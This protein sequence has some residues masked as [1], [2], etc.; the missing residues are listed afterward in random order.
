MCSLSSGAETLRFAVVAGNNAGSATMAPLRYAETDAGKFARVLVEL[1]EVAPQ[2]MQLLQGRPVRD[3]EQALAQVRQQVEQTKR[4]PETRTVLVFYFSGHSDGEGLEMGNEVLLYSRLR[5]MVSGI[6]DI[7][8]VIVDACNS[9]SGMREK[10]ARV[11]EPFVIKLNDTLNSSGDAY[12]SSSAANEAALESSEM[13]GGIFTHHLVS[14]LR[15]VADTSGDRLVTL[16]EAYRY[17]YEQTVSR[18]ALLPIGAQHPS[19]DYK[20]SGQGELV[21]S[22]LQQVTSRLVLPID[23]ERAVV[24][25]LMRDQVIAEIPKTGM[26]E[27]AVP[28]GQY[29]V[30]VFRGGLS[31]GGRIAVGTAVRREVGWSELSLITSSAAVATKGRPVPEAQWLDQRF[32]A[33]SAGIVPSVGAVG[34][35]GALRLGFEPRLRDGLNLALVGAHTAKATVAENALEARL[36]Y[37]FTWRFSNVWLGAGGEIGPAVIWQQAGTVALASFAGI[38]SP[39]ATVRILLENGL[40]LSL[41]GEAGLVVFGLN[42]GMGLAFRPSGHLGLGYRF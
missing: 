15:G 40:A 12:I 25:D 27:L 31:F 24:I 18:T 36:G 26:R 13:L 1:G 4:T 28:A 20:L 32:V 9:G 33:V 2:H 42:G 21:L 5:N 7:R 17:A 19:Y 8:V 35:Q 34:I 16:S 11:A 22:T 38:A 6:G 23:I 37:R 29:G 41:D 14:G 10:G 39:R 3:V 30:R